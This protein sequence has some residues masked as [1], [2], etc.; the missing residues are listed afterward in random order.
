MRVVRRPD[1]RTWLVDA[2]GDGPLPTGELY[3]TVDESD[4]DA[5]RRY[6]D[7]GFRIKRRES[8]YAVPTDG[9]R[10][11]TRPP[12]FAF[13]RADEVDEARLRVL[14]DTLRQDVPGADGWQWDEAGFRAETYE[15]PDFDPATYA[16]AV[17]EA[18]GEYVAIARVWNK[19]SRPR[20]G[21]IG[22][23]RPHRRR[24]LA[25][26]L[27][28]HVFAVLHERGEVEV[29]TEVDDENVASR[30]LFES[31]GARPTGAFLE[32]IRR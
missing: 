21:F 18:S 4:R 30:T 5:L 27:L 6:E 7:L 32:L 12:G 31:L 11:V 16:I 15:S 24:G 9:L 8:V 14:D 19:P 3:A 25:R 17:H 23:L 22:V 13:V 2:S 28:A 20:L 1:G 10:D 26:A 29:S